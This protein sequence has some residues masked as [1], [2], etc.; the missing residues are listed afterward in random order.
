MERRHRSGWA[1]AARAAAIVVGAAC[2]AA[3][4]EAEAAR[5]A[6]RAAAAATSSEEPDAPDDGPLHRAVEGLVGDLGRWRLSGFATASL[7][8]DPSDPDDRRIFGRLFDD[9]PNRPQPNRLSLTAERAVA[10]APG[11]YDWGA[12]LTALFGSDARYTTS[13]GLFDDVSDD[14]VQPD[15]QDAYVVLHAPWLFARGVELKGG[16]FPSLCGLESIDPTANVLASR[17]YAF[18][19]GVP[20][21]HLGALAALY[22][23]ADVDLFAGV[24]R[25]ANTGFRDNNGAASFHGGAAW[26]ACG[27]D[28]TFGLGVLYGPENPAALAGPGVDPDDDDRLIVDLN[29]T[30]QIADDWRLLV[31]LNYGRDGSALGVGGVRPEWFGAAATAVFAA[32]ADLDLALRAEV[33]RD[34]DGFAVAQFGAYDDYADVLLG[35]TSALDPRTR[36]GGRATYG[37]ATLG[38]AW[39]ATEA[40]LFQAEIRFD[41]AFGAAPF[42]GGTDDARWTF[43][44]A[45]TLR[46]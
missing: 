17:S 2:G 11:A 35:R 42:D 10:A 19:F 5:D 12:K 16:Y 32:S 43:A 3:G 18:N 13:T 25:G 27:G 41:A 34:D 4:Q 6:L 44:V 38:A 7:T 46:F 26:R 37:G 28:L 36:G 30:A 9:R 45:A 31:D 29:A 22:P 15:L 39:R 33:F 24:V 14:L 1:R 40:W 23:H 21:K 8:V 20:F